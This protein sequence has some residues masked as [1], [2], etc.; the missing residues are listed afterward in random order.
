MREERVVSPEVAGEVLA[1]SLTAWA[2]YWNAQGTLTRAQK[3]WR[4][5]ER[6]WRTNLAAQGLLPADWLVAD[7]RC[8]AKERRDKRS[9]Q[10]LLRDRA[11]LAKWKREGYSLDA[12]HRLVAPLRVR[13]PE[14]RETAGR[15]RERRPASRRA[16]P[17]RDPDEPHQ[18]DVIPPS[19]FRA[20]LQR[21]LGRT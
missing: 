17:S 1:R 9:M 4:E 20:E 3:R 8:G 16:A 11:K 2:A 15:P 13:A 14:R 18:L 5:H 6:K 21:A 12:E 7:I 10:S 19:A